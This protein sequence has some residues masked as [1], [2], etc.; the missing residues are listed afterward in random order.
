M[1][2][3]SPS[4]VARS[5]PQLHEAIRVVMAHILWLKPLP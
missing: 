4:Q 3:G 1:R 5:W 2:T